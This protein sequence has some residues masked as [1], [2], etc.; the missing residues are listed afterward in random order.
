MQGLLLSYKE[1]I[2]TIQMSRLPHILLEGSHDKVFFVRMCEAALEVETHNHVAITS[3]EQIRA[4]VSG[5]GNRDKVERVCELVEQSPLRCRFIGF[6]DRD[7]RGFRLGDS[8][9]DKLRTHRCQG[10]LVWS[11][12]HSIENYVFDFEVMKQPLLD[13][14]TNDEVA[15]IALGMLQEQFSEVIRIACALGIVALE[16]GT[17]ESSAPYCGLENHATLGRQVSMGY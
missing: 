13:F 15:M 16:Q 3:A 6:V 17:I 14:A 11:R 5:V 7:F 8:I 12:G 10:R 9:R 2:A 4:D 1:Y